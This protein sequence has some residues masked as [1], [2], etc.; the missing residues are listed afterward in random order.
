MKKMF[1]VFIALFSLAFSSFGQDA[2]T[3]IH[4]RA[5]LLAPVVRY[6]ATRFASEVPKPWYFMGLI[7]HESCI[8]LK[9]SKC[10]NPASEL[11]NNREHGV[12]FFQI[13][14]AWNEKTGML[15]FDNLT[16][17]TNRYK[18]HLN[19]LNWDTVKS[20]P[21][22]QVRAGILL[23]MESYRRYSEVPDLLER[24]K[25][26]DSAFNGGDSHVKKSRQICSL[27][28][29]CNP[30][31]WF[32]NVEKHLPKSKLPDKRYGGR[33]MYEINTHHVKDVFNVR[34]DKFEIYWK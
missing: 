7:E 15:R 19:G 31:I 28:K 3:Y 5:K 6:E 14:R 13:T 29:G 25:M 12:G 2:K 21:E 32:L 34:M 22:L 27:T 4:P 10:W 24:M 17:L 33:S 9:H 11:K 30:N 8:S 18:T 16:Y 1:L 26:T 23:W 20:K